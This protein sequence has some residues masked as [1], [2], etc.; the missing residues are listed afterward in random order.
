[1]FD[2][3]R[4]AVMVGALLMP[5][6]AMADE[7]AAPEARHVFASV[8]Q[9]VLVFDL[10]SL[11]TLDALG[12]EVAGVPGSN[13]PDYLSK[14]HADSYLKIGSLFEPDYETVSA[15]KPDLIIVGGRSAAKRAKLSEI[16]P[17]IDMTVSG[18]NFLAT[19]IADVRELG[20]IFGKVAEAEALIADID[21]ASARVK[22]QADKAG[23]V[24]MLMVNG[25]KL[26]AYGPGSRFGWL[27]DD[28]G[29]SPAVE[30]L[31]PTPHG[32][33]ISHEYIL[34]A[35]P[36]WL[37][38]LDR[39]AA[40]GRAGKSAQQVLDNPLVAASKAAKSGH[41]VYIDPVRWYLIGNGGSALKTVIEEVA[42]ALEG[43]SED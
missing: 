39:D 12:V 13:V 22:A 42:D 2:I 15:A 33:A 1:M 20:L 3:A 18:E 34:T 6:G 43:K 26:T 9:K 30:D 10:A 29:L 40:V 21:A 25:G 11:D 35:D 17:T 5:L 4:A 32:E 24:M 37:F 19:S 31:K 16:A 8:P 14:Y 7:V 36:D 23:S 27:H 28:L 38:V 41:I